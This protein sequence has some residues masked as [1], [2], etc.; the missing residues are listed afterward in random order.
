MECHRISWRIESNWKCHQRFQL[1]IRM[2]SQYAGFVMNYKLLCFSLVIFVG[3]VGSCANGVVLGAFLFNKRKDKAINKLIVN[4]IA[5]D[6][7]AS[8]ALVLSYSAKVNENFYIYQNNIWNAILCQ[9]FANG[10]LPFGGLIGS[11]VGL[12]VLTLERYFKIVH[13]FG[14]RENFSSW[15]IY[16]G[17]FFSWASGFLLEIVGSWTSG[18]MNGKCLKYVFWESETGAMVWSITLLIVSYFLPLV[19][20][21]FGY[22]EILATVR[23]R[24]DVPLRSH[25]QGGTSVGTNREDASHQRIQMK[26]VK[27]LITVTVAFIVCC[28][29]NQIYYMMVL[30]QVIIYFGKVF[31]DLLLIIDNYIIIYIP[32]VFDQFMR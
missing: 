28:S 7:F 1:I 31:T 2:K 4:Q 19:V 18:V 13:P 20:F 10:I 6:L 5:L 11:T 14:Y 16:V 29:P 12:V 27:M 15:M 22:G 25:V 21:F 30:F 23:R 9:F 32:S 17:I 3:L 26:I 24:S 8:V